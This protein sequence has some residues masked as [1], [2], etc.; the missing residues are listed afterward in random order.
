VRDDRGRAVA[1]ATLSAGGGRTATTDAAGQARLAGVSA[2]QPLRLEV[3]AAGHLAANP[4]VQ[5]PFPKEP[6]V[7]VLQRAFGVTGRLLDAEGVPVAAGSVRVEH[8][9]RYQDYDLQSGGRFELDLQPGLP[10]RLLLRSSRTRELAVHLQ[11]GRRGQLRDLGDLL[12]PPG[13]EVRGRLLRQSDGSAILGAR[14]WAPRLGEQGAL[15]AWAQGDLLQ[16]QS[17]AKGEFE[18]TGLPRQPTLLR[19]DAPGL[20][21]RHLTVDTEESL[22]DLGE[23]YLQ[24]GSRVL[25]FAEDVADGATARLDLRRRWM[26]MDM[27]SATV[28]DGQAELLHVPPGLANIS[29]LLDREL[30][31]EQQVEVPEAGLSEVD[32][33]QSPL[34]VSGS[35]TVGGEPSSGGRLLWQSADDIAV[36]GLINHRRSALGARSQQ[37][38]GAGRPQVEVSLDG[39]GEF[40][41]EGLRPGI[42]SVLWLESGA[43]SAPQ[44]VELPA[45]AVHEVRLNFPGRRIAG[46]VVDG[47]DLPVP[48][49]R[50]QTVE[51][52]AV[53][54]TD[55]AGAF[56]LT[57]LEMGVQQLFARA[58]A[59]SSEVAAVA[60]EDR[61]PVFLVLADKAREVVEIR[62][63]RQDGGPAAG[64]FVFLE[65]DDHQSR[66]LTLDSAGVA[67]VEL[68]PPYPRRLRAAAVDDGGWV[69]G[70]WEDLDS[71]RQLY[72]ESGETGAVKLEARQL[73][74]W[75]ELISADGWNLSLLRQRIGV[76]AWLSPE[77]PLVIDGLPEGEYTLRVGEIVSRLAV[78]A[79]DQLHFGVD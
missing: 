60:P 14:V 78:A 15:V 19:I 37:I 47:A 41:S 9:H 25:V 4:T 48:G 71:T 13:V 46:V 54:R 65:R 5:P 62:V 6:P 66:R 10:S 53:A 32:C 27:L 49:A 68:R 77:L 50:V 2:S 58:G 33:Q 22:L 52:T 70:A 44:R 21:R 42:W 79:D 74:G 59:R 29:V 39:A 24:A 8:G 7:V 63:S 17:G 3:S 57:G 12:A 1:G 30:L 51:G 72:L 20:A 23:I 67:R 56:T 28:V 73:E 38:Y 64:A 11:P 36:H 61:E 75:V 35:V 34:R 16:A 26:E 40:F 76:G 31:C 18:L 55:A 69:L 43:V 45:V